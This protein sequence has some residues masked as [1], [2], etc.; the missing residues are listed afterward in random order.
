MADRPKLDALHWWQGLGGL[1]VTLGILLTMGAWIWFLGVASAILLIGGAII[2]E[3]S[4]AAIRREQEGS[5][6]PHRDPRDGKP[7]L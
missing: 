6:D 4:N 5:Y 3:R 7:L 2:H 1:L